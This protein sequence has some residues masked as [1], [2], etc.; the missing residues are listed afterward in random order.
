MQGYGPLF[1]MIAYK[2]K[3]PLTDRGYDADAIWS[4]IALHGIQTVITA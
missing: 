3:P 2:L 1:R 4:E